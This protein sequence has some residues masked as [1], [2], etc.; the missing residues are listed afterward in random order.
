MITVTVNSIATVLPSTV[1]YKAT[2]NTQARSAERNANGKLVREVLPNKWSVKMEWDIKED[3]QK[4]YD[5]FA[6]LET[7]TLINFDVSFPAPDGTYRTA[8]MYVAPLA[9]ELLNLSQG[10]SGW[11]D[12]LSTTFVE[13]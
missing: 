7:L 9:A 1:S 4:Y 10:A 5:L 2:L 12:S 11:W 3:V 13:V 6:Y 8:E